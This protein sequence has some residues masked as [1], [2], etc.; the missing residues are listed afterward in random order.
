L[1]TGETSARFKML[2]LLLKCRIKGV[3]FLDAVMERWQEAIR[4]R[5]MLN[6][7]GSGNTPPFESLLGDLTDLAHLYQSDSVLGRHNTVLRQYKWIL[8]NLGS[9]ATTK[10]SSIWWKFALR[11]VMQ[12]I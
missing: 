7:A 2:G 3:H 6:D 1:I 10:W 8:S 5:R 4:D 9:S 11:I 12:E